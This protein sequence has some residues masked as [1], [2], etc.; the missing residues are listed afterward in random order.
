LDLEIQGGRVV[1]CQHQLI[2]VAA[3]VK[4][5]PEI[6]DLVRHALAPYREELSTVVGIT[7][8]ALNRGTMLET[9][10]DNFLLAALLE[11]S[12]AELAFSNGWRFGAPIIAGA[13]TVNDLY[14]MVPMNPPVSTVEL[15]GDE[16]LAMLEENLER[17]F[18][19]D[20]FNQMGGSVKR[21]LGLNAY[22][23][24]ENPPG[25]RVQQVFVGKE[26]LRPNRHYPTAF[27]TEQGVANKY[28]RNR[29]QSSV[30]AVEA[31][32]AYLARHSPMEAELRGT[33]VA[34]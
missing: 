34:A 16:L 27:V 18:A 30:R 22:I 7:A 5:D 31:M 25:Q 13:V 19:R 15:T 12:G 10:M 29:E 28:G 20:P 21:G 17:T 1:D 6:D 33:F 32:K 3:S 26:R 23:K 14:N 11:S 8:T 4:P 9:T 2:E 24:I